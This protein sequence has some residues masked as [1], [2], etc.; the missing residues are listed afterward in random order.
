[1]SS[2]NGHKS[3]P[4]SEIIYREDLYPRIKAD[5]ATIQRYADNLDVLPPVEVNQ[6]NELIDG[7]HRWTAHRKANAAQIA[8]T[9]TKTT[10]DIELLALAC[11]RN[12]AQAKAVADKYGVPRVFERW[13][14]M[15]EQVRPEI[16]V[17]AT[18]PHLHQA[19]ALQALARGAHVLC[20][21]PL[22]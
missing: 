10:S 22:A 21:K 20:E 7:Y 1:M 2:S 5:P 13:E 9:V 4:V 6:H 17:V 12:A 3:I 19:I 14:E 16:V 11:Q 15:L 18:P 8:V